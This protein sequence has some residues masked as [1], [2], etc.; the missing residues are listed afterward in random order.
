MAKKKK[1]TLADAACYV[2]DK[3][4]EFLDDGEFDRMG[5][6]YPPED[7]VALSLPLH[8][9]ADYYMVGY[10][11]L[12]ACKDDGTRWG[13]TLATLGDDGWVEHKR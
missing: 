6:K 11:D 2:G 9:Q 5:I 10:G 7:L 1:H 12:V 3:I 8:P 13:A 4:V